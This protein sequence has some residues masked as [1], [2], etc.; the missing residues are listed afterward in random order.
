MC[1]TCQMR[2]ATVWVNLSPCQV[3]THLEFSKF[4]I[5]L[6][7]AGT[8]HKIEYFCGEATTR[9]GN[10]FAA[11]AHRRPVWVCQGRT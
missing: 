6:D 1:D 4:F 10:A 2:R 8:C 7:L 3:L 5:A 9:R 11:N